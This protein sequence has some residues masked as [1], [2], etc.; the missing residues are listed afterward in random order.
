MN[1]QDII[2]PIRDFF[3]W[4]F[5]VLKMG[6]QG[7]NYL[8]MAAFAIALIYWTIKLIGYQKDEVVNR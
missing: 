2:F 6:G 1:F 8:L 3:L 5:D 4:T 7:F